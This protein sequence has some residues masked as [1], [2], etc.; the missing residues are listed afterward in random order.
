MSVRPIVLQATASAAVA[1]L[2][3]HLLLLP[4]QTRAADARAEQQRRTEL[5][6]RY[7]GSGSAAE[8][9]AQLE[10]LRRRADDLRSFW[11]RSGDAS[12]LYD[13]FRQAA[14]GAGVSIDRIEPRRGGP[15]AARGKSNADIRV[16]GYSLE[17]TGDFGE[18]AAFM[19]TL[20]TGLGMSRVESFTI[21][22]LRDP[23]RPDRLRATIATTHFAVHGLLGS[24][25]DA[26]EEGGPG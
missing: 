12:G 4:M 1:G 20:H 5:V 13:A 18:I 25:A 8:S 6:A 11:S 17:I 23:A 14:V 10:T 3:W 16:I 15:A 21:A 9:A 2:A 7:E 26:G 22:P 19:D 24:T